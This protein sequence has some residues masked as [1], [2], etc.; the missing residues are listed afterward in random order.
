MKIIASIDSST[1]L[2]EVTH[3]EVANLYGY[4]NTYDVPEEKRKYLYCV[5][6]T[7]PVAKI[8]AAVRSLREYQAKELAEAQ[9]AVD[10][11]QDSL[12]RARDVFGVPV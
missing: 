1:V 7:L 5:G 10:R 9:T 12:N 6:Q 4:K 3:D 2:I 11:I 8:H